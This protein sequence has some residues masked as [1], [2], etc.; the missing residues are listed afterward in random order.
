MLEEVGKGASGTV[1]KV[2]SNINNMIYAMKKTSTKHLQK[3]RR[4]DLLREV[5]FMKFLKHPN[6]LQYYGHFV[7]SSY[8]Y[9]ITEFADKGDLRKLIKN[10]KE[11]FRRLG[12]REIW[13][14]IW[15]LSL[16]LL[17]LHSHKIIHRDIKTLNIMV[18]SD[19]VIKIGDL[20]DSILVDK[21]NIEGGTFHKGNSGWN[22]IVFI[23][24]S[25]QRRGI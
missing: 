22:T 17:H 18:T 15:Q 21:S 16:G 20:G 25:N 7:E 23:P 8:L 14:I 12:E 24:R 13:K 6:I 1:Y 3:K 2:K 5:S 4:G 19:N 11:K 10:Q 9:I